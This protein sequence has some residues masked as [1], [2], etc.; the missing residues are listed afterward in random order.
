M[1]YK[2]AKLK[3]KWPNKFVEYYFRHPETE[4][5]HRFK[6]Y[7]DINRNKS[8]E[9]DHELLE[10]VKRALKR[11][12]NPFAD[13]DPYIPKPKEETKPYTIQRALKFFLLKWKE[14]GQDTET[15]VRYERAIRYFEEWLLLKGLQHTPAAD[16][17]QEQIEAALLHWKIKKGW[18]NRTYNNNKA[19]LSTCFLYLQKKGIITLN[20]CIDVVSQKTR[21]TK[22]RY[23]DKKTLTKIVEIMKQ[24][25]SYLHFAAQ[26]VYHLCVRSEKELQNIMVGN[27]YPDRMQV[28][29]QITKTK[30]DRYIPM[31]PAI[32]KVFQ[33]RNVFDYP[34]TDYLFSPP[35]KNKF[36][37][38]GHPG[39]E[40]FA[41]GFLSKRFAK[42]RKAAGLSSDFTLYGFKHTRVIHLKLD[43][44]K[45]ADI[46]NLTG[47]TDF[48]AYAAY[49]RD[50]GVDVN[51][52]T[53]N[54]VSRDI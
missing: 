34:G 21:S 41:R 1:S 54:S 28:L 40:P 22:H 32:L 19:F 10:A 53:L 12:F 14:R 43:G 49:L 9:Y 42:I 44:A 45:D 8:K 51:P 33:E 4:A 5:W 16:I 29:L 38:D 36:V 15:I 2:P 47:H 20:P 31:N 35:H 18:K 46:M 25:D 13:N 7:E 37:A 39:P 30:V 11:G 6:V 48:A 3:G 27:I 24:D 50:L 52:E 26:V 17:T 23:Y